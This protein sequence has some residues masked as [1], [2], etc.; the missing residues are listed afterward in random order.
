M[1][2]RSSIR[3]LARQ[4]GAQVIRRGTKVVVINKDNPRLKARQG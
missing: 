3:S 2:V 1:K 4:P